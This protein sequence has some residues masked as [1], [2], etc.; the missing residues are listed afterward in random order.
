MPSAANVSV[1]EIEGISRITK[2]PRRFAFGPKNPGLAFVLSLLI[3]G[4]GQIYNE[5]YE[6]AAAQAGLA[7]FGA[8]L[9]L[10]DSGDNADIGAILWIS[11]VLCRLLM[12]Q[13]LRTKSIFKVSL[14][15]GLRLESIRWSHGRGRGL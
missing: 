15:A 12:R 1:S 3:T 8:V 6:K 9:V 4:G 13:S 2:R 11:A 14:R 5:Q 10:E 7:I